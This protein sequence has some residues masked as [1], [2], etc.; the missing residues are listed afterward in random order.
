MGYVGIPAFLDVLDLRVALC[1]V[2]FLLLWWVLRRRYPPCPHG[3]PPPGPWG[4]PLIGNLPSLAFASGTD[5]PH[6]VF[7]RM[8]KQYG[9]IFSLNVLGQRMV[10]VHGYKAIREAFHNPSL[11]DRPELHILRNLFNGAEGW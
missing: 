6:V 9:P 4:W 8:A 3:T 11:S 5:E 10:V 1:A 2:V 7:M